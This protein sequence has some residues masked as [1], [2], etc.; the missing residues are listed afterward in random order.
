MKG[1]GR[2]TPGIEREV[3]AELLGER[4]VRMGSLEG[5]TF[6]PEHAQNRRRE[7]TRYK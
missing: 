5:D 4:K 3:A 6:Q 7:Q 2:V 1:Q